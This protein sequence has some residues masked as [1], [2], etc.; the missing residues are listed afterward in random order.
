MIAIA[1]P[2]QRQL[3]PTLLRMMTGM[4]LFL[5]EDRSG[6]C[7]KVSVNENFGI[8]LA[9]MGDIG[10]AAR[11]CRLT[12][13][14]PSDRKSSSPLHRIY[15]YITDRA[16]VFRAKGSLNS[17]DDCN[18]SPLF[19]VFESQ[20]SCLSPPHFEAVSRGIARSRRKQVTRF[21]VGPPKGVKFAEMAAGPPFRNTTPPFFPSCS[22]NDSGLRAALNRKE[23]RDPDTGGNQLSYLHRQ[24]CGRSEDCESRGE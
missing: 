14:S 18:P 7:L 23:Y 13:H 5:E 3:R 15:D 4:P 11:N 10:P 8:A 16:Q 19:A 22:E 17:F 24:N 9:G 21:L 2:S 6:G 1:P 12:N 20:I